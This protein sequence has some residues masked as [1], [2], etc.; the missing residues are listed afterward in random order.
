MIE[1]KFI[2]DMVKEYEIKEY[3]RKVLE[4]AGLSTIEIEKTPLGTKIIIFSS[5]PGLI[6]G[7]GGENIKRLTEE[8]K[9]KFKI[10]NPLLEIEEIQNPDLDPRIVAERVEYQ[11]KKFGKTKFKA[12]GYRNL[13]RM[14]NAG[15]IGAEITISGRIPGKRHKCWRFKAGKLPKNGYI[16][17]YIVDKGYREIH[18]NQ[19][20]V[21]IKVSILKPGIKTPDTFEL[22]KEEKENDNKEE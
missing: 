14:M 1:R 21:G 18:W 5:K 22:V 10:E 17:D 2:S 20:S 16:A 8:L 9:K 13:Q 4:T 19:G 3:L 6:V 11:L 7:K 12:I 15:A